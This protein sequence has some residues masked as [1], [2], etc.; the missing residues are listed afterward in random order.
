MIQKSNSQIVFSTDPDV[1][2]TNQ[3]DE[4]A[5]TVNPELQKLRIWLEKRPGGKYVSIVKGFI[6][7]LNELK[8][9]ERIIKSN[10]HCGGSI[11]NNEIILQGDQREK[12]LK[13]LKSLNY[14]V[15]LSGG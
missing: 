15:K 6:G 9:L 3:Q 10:C 13:I 4:K 2:L 8:N 5:D 7:P 1:S 12:V 11:K 14:S